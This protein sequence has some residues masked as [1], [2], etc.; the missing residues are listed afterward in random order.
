MITINGK[1]YPFKAGQTVLEAATAAG[2]YIPTLCSHPHLTAFGA[3]RLCLVQID[4][5][6]GLP[7][8]CTIPLTD[9]MNIRTESEDIQRLRREI[10][11]LMLSE[12]PYSCLV[13]KDKDLCV[14]YNSCTTKA[15]KITGCNL[16]SWKEGCEVRK[17][18]DYLKIDEITYPIHYHDYPLKREEPFIDRDYNLCV[19]CGRCVRVCEDIRGIGAIAFLNRGH[20]T[21]VGTAFDMSNV[22][23]GCVFCGACLDEC[24]TAALTGRATK[25]LAKTEKRTKTTCNFCG[26]GCAMVVEGRR[27]TVMRAQ[28][29]LEGPANKGQACVLGRFCIPSFFNAIGRLRYPLVRKDGVLTPVQWEEALKAAADGLKAHDPGDVRIIIS[30]QVTN[31]TAYLLSRMSREVLPGSIMELDSAFDTVALRSSRELLGNAGSSGSLV[32]INNAGTILIVGADLHLDHSVLRVRINAAHKRGAKVIWLGPM[33]QGEDRLVDY[34][35][36]GTDYLDKLAGLLRKMAHDAHNFE[37][38]NEFLESLVGFKDSKEST[39]LAK[40]IRGKSLCILLGKGVLMDQPEAVFTAAYNLLVLTRSPRG[41]I[42]LL[43]SNSQGISDVSGLPTAALESPPAAKAYYVTSG[44]AYVPKEADFLVLQDIFESPLMERADVVLPGTGMPEDAGTI[45][46][47][48]GRVQALDPIALAPGMSKQDWLIVAKLAIQMGG[49]G[50]AYDTAGQ[51]TEE[52]FK[53]T[54]V[55]SLGLIAKDSYAFKLHTME[56]PQRTAHSSPTNKNVHGHRGADIV[57]KVD[58]LR[59]LY[60]YWGVVE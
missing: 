33:P 3:C 43:E 44:N 20:K 7:T 16:C 42:L 55:K 21:R 32:A 36:P 13:C 31:E 52:M 25:W 58:D 2:V 46:S 17:V 50:F 23:A 11:L 48:E 45:T 40:L 4:N 27:S 51:V 24:P 56:Q 1:Q 8:A 49:A 41:L 15:G 35:Y 29:D 54:K 18:V 38:S 14:K 30:P 53:A 34:H 37:G 9:G 57:Y 59:R 6:R 10:M 26:V 19:L 60:K 22:E 47:L 28:A 39:E 5:V 12:H